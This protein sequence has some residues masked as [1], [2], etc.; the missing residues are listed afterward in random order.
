[1]RLI[2]RALLFSTIILASACTPYQQN[3]GLAGFIGGGGFNEIQLSSDVYRVTFQGNKY[4]AEQRAKDFTLLRCAELALENGY[5]YFRLV[6]SDF[7][8][9][10]RTK[11]VPGSL[12][13]SPSSKVISEP[14]SSNTIQLVYEKSPDVY[15]AV[16]IRRSIKAQY[17]I[18]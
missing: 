2:Y 4:T 15:D 8:L 14:S 3:S 6:N 7:N 13:V 16:I 9:R 12:N 5:S 1:M 17:G 10:Y 11:S 18:N